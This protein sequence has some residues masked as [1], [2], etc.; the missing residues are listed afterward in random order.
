MLKVRRFYFDYSI[1]L[2]HFLGHVKGGR[3]LR[4]EGRNTD[5]IEL[6]TKRKRIP[7]S[8]IEDNDNSSDDDQKPIVKKRRILPME[9]SPEIS[10]NE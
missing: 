1:R 9:A 10:E 7:S 3:T 4:G 8:E 6:I 2:F 5:E